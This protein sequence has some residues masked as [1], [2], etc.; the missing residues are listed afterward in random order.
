MVLAH[1][2]GGAYLLPAFLVA[3]LLFVLAAWF[4]RLRLW[5]LPLLCICLGFIRLSYSEQP[6]SLLATCLKDEPGKLQN[7]VIEPRQLLSAEYNSYDVLVRRVGAVTLKERAIFYAD[8]TLIPGARYKLIGNLKELVS[9]PILDF[10]PG[11]YNAKIYPVLGME[12]VQGGDKLSL[13]PA[14]RQ[15]LFRQLKEN[16]GSDTGLA[17]ALLLSDLSSKAEMRDVLSRGGLVHLIVVSGLH[18]Y[19]IYYLIITILGFFLPRRIALFPAL[20]L[21]LAFTALNGWS[22]PVLRSLLMILIFSV[23][24]LLSRRISS[25]QVMALSLWIVSL[26]TPKEIFGL[27][28][29]LS[30]FSVFIITQGVPQI[31]VHPEDPWLKRFPR[32]L[33]HFVL[34][35]VVASLGILPLTLYHFG[36]GS[37]N[38]IIGNLVAIPLTSLL[39]PLAF[40]LAILPAGWGITGI[41]SLSY[42]FLSQFF[43]DWAEWIAKLPFLIQWSYISFRVLLAGLILVML[44]L[45]LT[46]GRWFWLKR[47]ALPALAIILLLIFVP[48]LGRFRPGIYIYNC[49]DADCSLIRLD[50][51]TELMIDTGGISGL[52]DVDEGLSSKQWQED[53][54]MQ[55]R[56]L[57]HLHKSG[58]RELELLVITHL[59]NDHVG[60]LASL[61]KAAR[62]K[63]L[64][65]DSSALESDLWQDMKQE[66]D[67]SR[68]EVLG[69]EEGY[70]QKLGSAMLRILHPDDGFEQQDLNNRSLVLRLDWLGKRILYTGD[71]EEEA[72]AYLLQNH[73]DELQAD[74]LKVPHHG[75]ISSSSVDFVKAVGAKEAWISCSGSSRFRFPHPEVLERYT[76]EGT[77][78]RKT[79]GKTIFVPD[80]EI[81]AEDFLKTEEKS[82]RE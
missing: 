55:R 44:L 17:Q 49:G 78:V 1:H 51:D 54:W 65:L 30:Y 31:W 62:V 37:L 39:L 9:D 18:I 82:K 69:V 48:G 46:S 14:L 73:T 32:N 60:G 6:K 15:Q 3:V 16:T 71:I 8:S 58:V 21:A 4:K 27:S 19:F 63:R 7:L 70:S 42:L 56:L 13:I 41:F 12:L 59:H 35:S 36:M 47:W 23:G 66:M 33:L 80:T 74:F 68:T 57:R 11:K 81:T 28:L 53:N 38:G 29:Q 34:T 2:L 25:I 76:A 24:K 72:E 43:M 52:V 50:K 45:W 5:I 64:L 10:S 79:A 20:L 61:L 40:L 26:I 75:S 67:L 22:P 77:R